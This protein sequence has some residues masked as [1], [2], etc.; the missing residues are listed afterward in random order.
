MAADAVTPA[1]GPGRDTA[2]DVWRGLALI[3][4]FINHVS[5]NVL[6]NLTHKNFGFSDA[7]E[8][9][10][11]FAGY[12][13]ASAYFGR[14]AWGQKLSITMKVVSR[15]V[16]LYVTHLALVVLGGAV[17]S[18]GVIRTGDLGLFSVI[19]LDPL[20]MDPA[21]AL[22]SAVVLRYQPGF[23]NILPLYFVL[24]GLLPLLLALAA[25]SVALAL[26]LSGALYLLAGL[27][28]LNFQTYPLPGGWFFN[29]LSWQF[30]FV[31]GFA[32]GARRLRRGHATTYRRG[33]W[34]AAVAYLAMALVMMQG[35]GLPPS[36]WLPLP[37]FFTLPE[38]QFL[39]VPRLLHVL[40]LCYVVA[41]SPLQAWARRL[42]GQNPLAMLGRHSLPVFC[43]G[44]VVSITGVALKQ[45]GFDGVLFDITYVTAGIAVQ[46]A[47]AALMTLTEKRQGAS[48]AAAAA[49][50]PS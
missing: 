50:Q 3:T 48:R 33:L 40:A 12:A 43:T 20:M 8:L 47:V 22:V 46:L 45:T 35:T 39:S 11:F 29:P 42:P 21:E 10:V 37:D 5:G 19:A 34:W 30:L 49:I 44:L 16:S 38:K 13:A 24:I 9:F 6:E 14:Y 25:R 7:A 27:T 18:M 1:A 41:H 26:G 31:L 17:F 32:L 2:L 15:A 23:L 28:G 4:I 36:G